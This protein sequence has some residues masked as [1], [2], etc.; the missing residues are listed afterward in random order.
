VLHNE[1][2]YNLYSSTS[3]I[4]VIKWRRIR[5][6]EHVARMGDRRG[7]IRGL[8]GRPEGKRPLGRRRR[9]C[10]DNIKMGLQEA[11]WWVWTGLIWVRIGTDSGML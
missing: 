3:I 1:E 2:V 10:E 9:R 7:A 8:V 6:A 11:G 5:W 4:R